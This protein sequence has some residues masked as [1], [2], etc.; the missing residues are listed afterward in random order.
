MLHDIFLVSCSN[1]RKYDLN[2]TELG[3]EDWGLR[4]GD[5]GLGFNRTQTIYHQDKK[6]KEDIKTKQQRRRR[7]RTTTWAINSNSNSKSKSKINIGKEG[8]ECTQNKQNKQTNKTNKQTK[9]TNKQTQSNQ[10][11]KYFSWNQHRFS[12]WCGSISLSFLSFTFKMWWPIHPFNTRV[13]VDQLIC[14]SISQARCG[15][16]I[17]FHSWHFIAISRC[18]CSIIWWLHIQIWTKADSF[19]V[20]GWWN[21]HQVYHSRWRVDVAQIT[22]E[23]SWWRF[24]ILFSNLY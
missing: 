9:Q 24:R 16:F 11:S 2:G 13:C 22:G 18:M 14:H 7:R 8:R 17:S 12:W 6:G 5:W 23:L 10:W 15:C 21:Q 20:G 1:L 3:I 19:I 4:I